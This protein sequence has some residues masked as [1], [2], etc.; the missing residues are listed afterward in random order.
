[1]KFSVV[2]SVWEPW[3]LFE[4]ALACVMLQTHINWEIIIVS[5]GHPPESVFHI[6]RLARKKLKGFNVME[7]IT[8]DR[9][10]GCW[11]NPAR[12]MGMEAARGDY[13]CWVN[14]DNIIFP[15]YLAAHADNF[16]R[17]R[18]CVSVVPIMLRANQREIGLLPKRPVRISHIDL[19]NFALPL[20]VAKS[21]G[22]FTDDLKT[23]YAADWPIYEKASKILPVVE[24]DSAVPLGIHF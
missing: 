4:H 9:A 14:H 20:D 16:A 8:T 19:M 23:T 7:F 13:V 15:N 1:M 22:A 24:Y 2:M 11:G 6:V 18:A 10:E 21:I 3:E 5:D 12:R 17:E